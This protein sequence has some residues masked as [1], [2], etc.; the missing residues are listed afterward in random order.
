MRL[1]RGLIVIN[2]LF[3]SIILFEIVVYSWLFHRE[4]CVQI[5]VD[6]LLVI[7]TLVDITWCIRSWKK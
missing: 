1:Y 2:I 6:I 4:A 3:A 5:V 7:G